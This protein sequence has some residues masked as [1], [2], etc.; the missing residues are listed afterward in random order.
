[1][2]EAEIKLKEV[3]KGKV[4][5]LKMPME[6]AGTTEGAVRFSGSVNSYIVKGRRNNWVIIDTGFY[7]ETGK[8]A[9]NIAI[10]ELGLMPDTI[11]TVILTHYHSDHSGM[12]GWFEEWTHASV[13]MHILDIQSYYHEWDSMDENVH[14]IMEQLR[15]YGMTEDWEKEVRRQS[16]LRGVFVKK[17]QK[18]LAMDEN[19]R[20]PVCTGELRVLHVPG[21]TDGQCILIW[22]EEQVMF[23]GDLLLPASFAPIGLHFFGDGNPV[24]T[25]VHTLSML[26]EYDISQLTVL[27][28]H[29]WAFL[30]PLDRAQDTR[31]H[32]LKKADAYYQKCCMGFH[33]AWEIALEY[34]RERGDTSGVRSVMWE[35]MAYLEYLYQHGQVS[36]KAVKEGM[37]PRFMYYPANHRKDADC[38]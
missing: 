9:W 24:K 37:E 13:Y 1:M 7:N 4:W 34:V 36:R 12:S 3:V 23:S 26:P 31:N 16:Y 33:S 17:R 15:M 8:N 30:R 5:R 32:Y 19:S 25:A 18:I 2:T 10:K 6:I 21:H 20:F 35:S 28:G 14:C 27:P 38:V 11:E 22:P 29:G